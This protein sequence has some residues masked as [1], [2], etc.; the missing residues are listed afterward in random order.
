MITGTLPRAMRSSAGCS[1]SLLKRAPTACRAFQAKLNNL[2][3]S[4]QMS[5]DL[6]VAIGE[7]HQVRQRRRFRG[8]PR[9]RFAHGPWA[10]SVKWVIKNLAG[11]TSARRRS[12]SLD[13]S[14]TR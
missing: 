7:V 5:T 8:L 3:A 10:E 4:A 12:T 1:G 13:L 14:A 2:N 11:R 6:N 9:A